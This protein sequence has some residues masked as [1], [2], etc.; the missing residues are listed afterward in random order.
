MERDP[1]GGFLQ[2]CNALQKLKGWIE[3]HADR[4]VSQTTKSRRF[5]DASM[6]DWN[7]HCQN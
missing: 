6:S 5:I 7:M 1:F 3:S 4:D 2:G